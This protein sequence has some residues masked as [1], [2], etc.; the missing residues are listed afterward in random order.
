MSGLDL[1]N[2]VEEI[3]EMKR[4]LDEYQKNRAEQWLRV[5]KLQN[6]NVNSDAKILNLIRDRMANIIAVVR[7]R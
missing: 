7:G 3:K 2:A 1:D 4:I 5:L 6:D